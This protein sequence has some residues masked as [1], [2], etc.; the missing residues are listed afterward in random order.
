[1]KAFSPIL[2]LLFPLVLSIELQHPSHIESGARALVT[3]SDTPTNY[4][5]YTLDYGM[6]YSDSSTR[7]VTLGIDVFKTSSIFDE[8]VSV[9][10]KSEYSW[11]MLMNV[12]T[13]TTIYIQ[14]L[15]IRYLVT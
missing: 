7:V 1:M 11:A 5:T 8:Y 12:S 13:L 10:K 9:Q 14:A 6:E 2:L 3:T 15:S 4:L